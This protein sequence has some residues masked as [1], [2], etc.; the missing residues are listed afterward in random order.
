MEF[1]EYMYW[2]F[3]VGDSVKDFVRIWVYLSEGVDFVC[4]VIFDFG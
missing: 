2:Y 4:V 3:V 1:F